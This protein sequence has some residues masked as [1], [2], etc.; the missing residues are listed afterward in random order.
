M[1]T[2][3]RTSLAVL[4]VD[5]YDEAEMYAQAFAA[6]GVIV[7]TAKTAA[8]AQDRLLGFHPDIIIQGLA[9]L[10]RS[11][12]EFLC[13]V[14]RSHAVPVIVLSGFLNTVIRDALQ[15]AGA[16]VVVLKPCVPSELLRHI[17]RVRGSRRR[18]AL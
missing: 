1:E 9:L 15:L 4:I 10:D 14:K 11:G 5:P 17:E 16:D 13:S 3:A 12:I 8:E 7:Q 6:D 18:V 2:R